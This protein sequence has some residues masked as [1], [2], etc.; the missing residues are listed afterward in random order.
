MNNAKAITGLYDR[1]QVWERIPLM[2]AAEA[3]NDDAEYQRLTRSSPVIPS[4][5]PAH[6]LSE[7]S[8]HVSALAYVCEQLD[9]AANHFLALWSIDGSQDPEEWLLIADTY[10]F[11][12]AS[13]AQ[14]WRQYC[15]E[16]SIASEALVGLN[17]HGW[18]L[19][20]CEEKMPANAPSAQDLQARWLQI[21]G[22][23]LTLVTVNQLVEKWHRQLLDTVRYGLHGKPTR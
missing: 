1:L 12:F 22:E 4:L 7:V 16:L 10:A 8:I 18:L 20:Y 6:G 14:A 9:A 17:H 13:N 5:L 21:K 15:S 3:R 19:R 11:F 23:T 2:I